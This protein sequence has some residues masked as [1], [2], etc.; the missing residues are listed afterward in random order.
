MPSPTLRDVVT[1]NL[2][3]VRRRIEAACLRSGRPGAAVRL[4]AVTKY[5]E[6]TWIR[7]LVGLGQLDL[8]ESRPQQLAVR[9]GEFSSDVRW[10]LI[11][12]LQRNKAA[13]VLPHTTLIHSVDSMRLL[14]QLEKDARTL[15]LQRDVL[16]EINV[17]GEA[18]KDGFTPNAVRDLTGRLGELKFIRPLGL[19]TMAPLLDD[20]E[21]AR[22]CFRQLRELRDELQQRSGLPLPELSMGMSGDFEPAVEEGATLVRIGSSLFEGLASE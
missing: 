6:P 4:V 7:E 3:A 9:A 5:A 15:G 20:P 22:S 10:H 19:M 14:E 17:S 16:L 2:V 21:G 18:S 1:A 8:G 12:H 11:G 13:L